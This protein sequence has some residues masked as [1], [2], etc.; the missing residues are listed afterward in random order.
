METTLELRWFVKGIPPAV[1]RRWFRLECPGKWLEPSE[2]R[3]DWYAN[4]LQE[5]LDKF[6]KLSSR[7][8][9]REE[10]N[11]KLR[12][13]NLELKLR[14]QEFGLHRFGHQKN[15]S[16][17]EGKVEQWCKF[18]ESEL[19]NT[20][21][22][23]SSSLKTDWVSVDKEREQ[24]IERGVA[25]ELTSLKINNES[26]W[27]IAFEMTQNDPARLE[28]SCFKQ[29]VETACQ[30]YYGPKLSAANSYGYSRWLLEF[31]PQSYSQTKLG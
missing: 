30:S 1:V 28:D 29:V 4:R 2:S 7:V 20:I 25:S 31:E 5:Y 3:Q 12:Q 15:F 17:C 11:L 16:N 19:K 21:S 18:G 8:L 27:T 14:Q 22:T 10:V 23:H 6:R 9:N 26:W 13:G 24:K